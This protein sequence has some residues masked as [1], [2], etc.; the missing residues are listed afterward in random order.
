M[1]RSR[2]LALI[3]T[4]LG[5]GSCA[6]TPAAELQTLGA[7]TNAANALMPSL[8]DRREADGARCFA[9]AGSAEAEACL[10][11]VGERYAPVWAAARALAEADRAAL[12]GAGSLG[13]AVRAF[14]E[15]ASSLPEGASLP[16]PPGVVCPAGGA[17]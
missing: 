15:L 16:I 2:T 5:L 10:D 1:I 4:A 8:L 14:C 7:M 12:E 9:D 17:R 3:V 6:C 11:R 13:A